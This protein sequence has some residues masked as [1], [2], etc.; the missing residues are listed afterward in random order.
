MFGIKRR[1]MERQIHELICDNQRRVADIKELE[2]RFW[3]FVELIG[4]EHGKKYE[5]NY[6]A[7]R[8]VERKTE[9]K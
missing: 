5:P 3:S 2:R 9:E 1:R 7:M 6:S 8:A 4:Q